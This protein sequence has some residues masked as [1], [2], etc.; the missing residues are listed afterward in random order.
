MTDSELY[1]EILNVDNLTEELY[2]QVLD[3]C[4]I[5]HSRK[6]DCKPCNVEERTEGP[7][8]GIKF[9][10]L[11]RITGY[12]VGDISRWNDGKRSELEDRAKHG[13]I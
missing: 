2:E 5:E 7:G 10:R 3:R 4:N 8:E 6:P 11:R 9:Q 12:L 1:H 13:T